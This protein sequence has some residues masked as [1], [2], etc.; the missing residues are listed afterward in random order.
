MSSIAYHSHCKTCPLMLLVCNIQADL[1]SSVEQEHRVAII[2]VHILVHF[3]TQ[4]QQERRPR[5]SR[6]GTDILSLDAH[7]FG[8]HSLGRRKSG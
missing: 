2:S 1:Q 5:P 3:S 6:L 4:P 7:G 8:F